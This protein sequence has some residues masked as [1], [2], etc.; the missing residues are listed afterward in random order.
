MGEQIDSLDQ[1]I[2]RLID[3]DDDFKHM[4]TLLR[5]APGV[6]PVLSSTL[7]A[8]LSELGTTGRQDIAALVGVAPFDDDS[9]RRTGKRVIRG[10][11]VQVRCV[12]YMAALAAVRCN[13]VLKRFAARLRAA[14]K[15]FKVTLVACM[16]KLLALLNAMIRDDLMWSQL[17]VVKNT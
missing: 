15:S 10:G 1:Q 8:E 11:R 6:G 9:G 5:S 13:P 16:R 17:D 2:R 4:D 3:S 12:L 14:G 7:V